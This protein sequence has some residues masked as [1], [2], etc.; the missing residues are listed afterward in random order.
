LSLPV[1]ATYR[2]IVQAYG[3]FAYNAALGP[4]VSGTACP[5]VMLMAR[6]LDVL[7]PHDVTGITRA[8]K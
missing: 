5:E 6:L 3:G 8:A 7:A 2:F 4:G 1:V